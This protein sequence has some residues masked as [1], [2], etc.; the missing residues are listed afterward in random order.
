MALRTTKSSVT[1]R[2]PFELRE[3]D[4]AQPAGTYDI[5]TDEEI[6]E[7]NERT[8]Y[9]RVATLLH[10]RKGGTT[11]IVTIDPAGLQAALVKDGQP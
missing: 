8:V 6:V 10:L 2:A 11:R 4:E 9:I 7:G 5:V 1:F 3:L